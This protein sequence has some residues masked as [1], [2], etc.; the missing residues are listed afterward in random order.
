MSCTPPVRNLR[1][2]PAPMEM[3]SLRSGNR[4]EAFTIVEA[5]ISTIIVA[6]MFVAA[7]NTVG[8]SRV[9]QYKASQVIRGQLMAESLLS[10]ILQQ[11]YE[12][13]D[14]TPI[15]GLETGELG[16]TRAAWDDVDDYEEF[17]ESPPATKDG[18]VLTNATGWERQV[19]VEWVAASDPTTAQTA[20][21]G[22]KRVVVTVRYTGSPQTSLAALKA[23]VQ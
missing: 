21:T 7:L 13:P 8:A 5:M 19:R 15:F 18:T 16:T 2:G 12:D 17:T 22:I 23:D 1:W 10:E 3:T 14:G 20:E 6:M 4:P 11:S 9:T